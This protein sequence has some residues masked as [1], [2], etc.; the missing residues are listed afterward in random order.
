MKVDLFENKY[1]PSNG[2]KIV[3]IDIVCFLLVAIVSVGFCYSYFSHRI[4]VEGFSTTAKV[5]VEYQYDVTDGT[6]ALVSDV[7]ATVNGGTEQTLTSITKTQPLTPGDTITIVGRAYNA[8]NVQV[9][10]LAR[11]EVVTSKGTEVVWY[12]IGTND[13]AIDNGVQ[14][15][16]DTPDALSAEDYKTLSIDETTKLYT[17]GAGS[18]G[19]YK[20]KELA[21][22]YEI[23]KELENGDTV[24]SINL[25]LHVH[26]KKYLRSETSDFKL[27]SKYENANKQINGYD[28][29][30]IYAAHYITGNKLTA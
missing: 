7:Y 23:S 19:A 22:P 13:P 2:L 20:Y 12:N 29:E 21:I 1:R 26:Q 30:S 24:T 6:Y 28:T 5:D 10:V 15:G 18:L 11:L 3:F 17:V 27:Y 14:T 4:D 8:S 9:Y 16:A 25:T